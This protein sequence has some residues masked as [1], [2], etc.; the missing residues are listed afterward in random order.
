M[1]GVGTPYTI[2]YLRPDPPLLV[3]WGWQAPFAEWAELAW[4][5]RGGWLNKLCAVEHFL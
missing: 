4:S 2:Y 1:V 5:P 3:G